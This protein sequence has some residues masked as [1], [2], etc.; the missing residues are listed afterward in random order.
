M[1]PRVGSPI[2]DSVIRALYAEKGNREDFRRLLR[3]VKRGEVGFIWSPAYSSDY[4]LADQ[5]H[6]SYLEETGC[7]VVDRTSTSRVDGETVA[8][9]WFCLSRRGTNLLDL[10]DDGKAARDGAA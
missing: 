2:D 4:G 3:A 8:V 9:D 7:I 5:G 1:T 6:L 10:L